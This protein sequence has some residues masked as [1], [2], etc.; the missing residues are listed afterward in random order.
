MDSKSQRRQGTDR[1]Y[2]AN[3]LSGGRLRQV[4]EIAPPRVRRYL[5]A[6]IDEILKQIRTGDKVLELGCGYG[7]VMT[8]L[9]DRAGSVTG[10]D[11]SMEN[12]KFAREFLSPYKNLHLLAMDAAFLGFADNTFDLTIAIQNGISAFKVPPEEL[13]EESLRV[14]KPGGRVLLSTYCE[15]FWEARLEWFVMQSR[16]GLLGE[17]DWEKTGEGVIVCKDGFC[18]KAISSEKFHQLLKKFD[19]RYRLFE[20]DESSLICELIK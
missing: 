5:Q 17:I 3:K 15:K 19:I 9:A 13:L 4:Y 20:V 18:A 10:I 2:Y 16:A 6:E 7:R 14:T 11:S 8:A 12:L 1:G